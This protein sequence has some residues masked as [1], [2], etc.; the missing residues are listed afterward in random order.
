MNRKIK[1][2]TFAIAAMMV[3]II[4]LLAAFLIPP[5][6]AQSLGGNGGLT[7]FQPNYLTTPTNI[8][9]TGQF[10]NA[11]SITLT[12]GQ[13]F[14]ITSGATDVVRQNNGES[15][16]LNETGTNVNT[17]AT[18]T[19]WDVTADGTNWTTDH[20]LV[21]AITPGNATVQHWTN[22]PPVFLNN[23]RAVKL[24]ALTNSLVG[25]GNT[26]TVTLNWIQF[27]RSQVIQ[28]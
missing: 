6:R 4:G 14:A 11:T 7:I 2:S 15:I 10:T 9:V 12:N 22:I 3:V 8:T 20:P 5:A 17:T 26:N 19:Y 27:S 1:K 24:S 16:L 25:T 13:G 23:V 21:I 18:I 28:Y